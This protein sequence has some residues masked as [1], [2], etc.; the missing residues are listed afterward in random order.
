MRH[1]K[2]AM[3]SWGHV[4]LVVGTG[5]MLSL[6]GVGLIPAVQR[7]LSYAETSVFFSLNSLLG[8]NPVWDWTFLVTAS[9]FW[10]YLAYCASFS[11]FVVHGWRR[12]RRDYGR[13]FGYI[14]FVVVVVCLSEEM[15]DFVA[16]N[17]HRVLPWK[18]GVAVAIR[19]SYDATFFEMHK[20]EGIVDDVASALFCLCFLVVAAS[21]R[22]SFVPLLLLFAYVFSSIAV[23]TQWL[24]VQVASAL[25]GAFFAGLAL[26]YFGAVRKYLEHKASE[27]FVSAFGHYVLSRRLFDPKNPQT[28]GGFGRAVLAKARALDARGKDRLWEQF[29]KPKAIALLN[30]DVN[31]TAL[32]TSPDLTMARVR[33]GK[34]IRFLKVGEKEVFAVRAIRARGGLLRVSPSFLRFTDGVKNN[35]YLQRLGFPVPRVI[36]TQE[37]VADFGLR[38]WFLAVEEFIESRCLDP[39]SL[40]EVEEAM[41][42]LVRL[43]AHASPRWGGLYD[44]AARTKTDYVLGYLR[45]SVLYQ[46]EKIDKCHKLGF[47]P[48]EMDSL[49]RLFETE[50]V[51]VLSG[52]DTSF[53]LIHGD[54]TIRNIRV[55]KDSRICM[56]DFLTVRNDLAGAEIVKAAVA[57]TRGCPAHCAPAWQAYFEEAGEERWREF[58]REARLAFARFAVRELAHLRVNIVPKGS[59]ARL[60]KPEAVEWI[61]R[62]FDTDRLWGATPADTD[63]PAILRVLGIHQETAGGEET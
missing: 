34:R 21:P 9:D 29:V 63:W 5:G 15:A 10:V 23:G 59:N 26:T 55:A 48:R 39:T 62:L 22:A 58:N 53:R 47:E 11:A 50:T 35:V 42:L 41:R 3:Q 36:W 44:D 25:M 54:V 13:T 16:D 6:Y 1:S 7:F 43:H 27:A 51:R 24:T 12:R 14:V 46:I 56:I 49:W 61:S 18:Q 31:A 45:R 52:R 37:G 20:D 4:C 8:R 57:L 17:L 40:N 28:R 60:R 19:A 30:A 2:I 33:S 38:N 32:Y